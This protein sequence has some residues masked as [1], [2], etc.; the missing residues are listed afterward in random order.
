MLVLVLIGLVLAFLLP[1]RPAEPAQP[2][3]PATIP[4]AAR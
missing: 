4:G 3:V 2:A 1:R